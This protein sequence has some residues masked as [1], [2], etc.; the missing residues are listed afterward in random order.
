MDGVLRRQGW[1]NMPLIEGD[2]KWQGETI[3]AEGGTALGLGSRDCSNDGLGG[4]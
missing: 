3:E 1:S 4:G 2:W